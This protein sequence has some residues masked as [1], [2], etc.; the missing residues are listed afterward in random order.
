MHLEALL[1]MHQKIMLW[2]LEKVL[3]IKLKEN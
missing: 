1:R 3:I 2:Q